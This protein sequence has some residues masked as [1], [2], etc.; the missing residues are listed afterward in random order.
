MVGGGDCLS[1]KSTSSATSPRRHSDL[2]RNLVSLST[3]KPLD[4]RFRGNDGRENCHCERL[5]KQSRLPRRLGLLAKTA[6]RG[7]FIFAHRSMVSVW[8]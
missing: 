2:S 1:A 3:K 8:F 5:A 7:A 6:L 4:S